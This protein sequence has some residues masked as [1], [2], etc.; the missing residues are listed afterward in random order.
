M[1]RNRE[2]IARLQVQI[3]REKAEKAQTEKAQTPTDAHPPT[4]I[5]SAQT[6]AHRGGTDMEPTQ[7]QTTWLMVFGQKVAEVSSA[8]HFWENANDRRRANRHAEE[9]DSLSHDCTVKWNKHSDA[10]RYLTE[11]AQ[12]HPYPV[13]DQ[14][15][16]T[17][18]CQIGEEARPPADIE[19]YRNGWSGAMLA[20]EDVLSRHTGADARGRT[21]T[22]SDWGVSKRYAPN[23][24][25]TTRAALCMP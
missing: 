8:Y 15:A 22:D 19:Q 21:Q 16:Q 9:A 7:A 25:T 5:R 6:G 1:I 12:A 24:Q 3:D 4:Q 18:D 14:T 17:G 10:M 23:P 11:W 20:V 2:A 13:A